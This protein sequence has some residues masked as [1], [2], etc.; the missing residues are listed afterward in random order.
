MWIL[1]ALG[2]AFFVGTT[3]A[4]MKKLLQQSDERIV[5]WGA[6]LFSL[7]WLFAVGAAAGWPSLSKDFWVVVAW[8]VPLELAAFLCQLRAIRIAPMSLV[9]PFLAFTPALTL[10]TGWVLLPEKITIL[11]FVG[12]SAVT[13]GAYAFHIEHAV[14]GPLE[15]FR[16]LFRTPG[17][18][19]MLVT[20]VLYSVTSVLSKKGV[21]LSSAG[22]FPFLY[23]AVDVVCLT[24]IARSGGRRFDG[25]AR[26]LRPRI[27]LYA[28]TGFTGAA[29]FLLHCLGIRLAP[30]P[31]FIAL[32]RLSLLVS[33]LYGGLLYKEVSFA[34][35]I[36]ATALMLSGAA[37]IALAA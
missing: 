32:K 8:M 13:L 11:G 9:V 17:I 26:E 19:L 20:A 34:K 4:L 37:L 23:Y 33:V 25:M 22:T 7:P 10:L 24:G 16:E 21:L 28:L 12:V 36:A 5:G 3:D 35:R 29:G 15:P 27:G 31:Y 18:R 6:L 14:R 30:V 2:C 1:L